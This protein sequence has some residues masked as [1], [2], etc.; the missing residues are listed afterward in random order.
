MN[1]AAAPYY[2]LL[3]VICRMHHCDTAKHFPV[4]EVGTV[5][6]LERNYY[7]NTEININLDV[8]M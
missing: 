1:N 7:N 4:N 3:N 8:R 5:Y 6:E 2:L